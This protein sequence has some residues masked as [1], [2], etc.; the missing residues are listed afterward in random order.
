[1]AYPTGTDVRPYTADDE[2][3][4]PTHSVQVVDGGMFEGVSTNKSITT[5][6]ATYRFHDKTES[7]AIYT[8]YKANAGSSF[9]A[10]TFIDGVG[11]DVTARYSG[12][13][14]RTLP[15]GEFGT[16]DVKVSWVIVEAL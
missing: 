1:M 11:D 16:W 10:K 13:P 4:V 12:K 14:Q 5:Y 7:D 8:H 3:E 6:N 9:S 2:V 15:T